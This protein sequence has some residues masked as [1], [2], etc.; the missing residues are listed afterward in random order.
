MLPLVLLLIPFS[1][2][3]ITFSINLQNARNSITRARATACA[4]V[5]L[6]NITKGNYTSQITQIRKN[7]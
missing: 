6:E 3:E 2:F 1:S 4:S 5:V 7:T